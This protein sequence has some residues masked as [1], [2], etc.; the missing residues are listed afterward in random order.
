[1]PNRTPTP[2]G[3]PE[4]FGEPVPRPTASMPTTARLELNRDPGVSIPADVDELIPILT[5]AVELA[6]AT[7]DV[8]IFA[9][10]GID[11]VVVPSGRLARLQAARDAF[12]EDAGDVLVGIAPAPEATA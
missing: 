2:P 6:N 12:V 1:M 8:L 7:E 10:T 3:E 4:R 9:R 5:A 11:P